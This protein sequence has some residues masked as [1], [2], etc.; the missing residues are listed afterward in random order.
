MM[1]Q[2]SSEMDVFGLSIAIFH[3]FKFSAKWF[4]HMRMRA[5]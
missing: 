4:V 2:T 1:A 3:G 5:Q